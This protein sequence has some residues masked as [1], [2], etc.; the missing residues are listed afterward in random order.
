MTGEGGATSAPPAINHQREGQSLR[1]VI[2]PR[3]E[4]PPA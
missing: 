2:H 4:K 1:F 3:T